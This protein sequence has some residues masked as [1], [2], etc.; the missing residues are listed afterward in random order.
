MYNHIKQDDI[1]GNKANKIFLSKV[2]AKKIVKC[3][4]EALKKKM[5]LSGEICQVYESE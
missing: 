3:Y 5:K 2:S 1:P 4:W